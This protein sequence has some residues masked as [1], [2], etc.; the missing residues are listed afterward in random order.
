M[1][2][3][4]KTIKVKTGNCEHLKMMKLG[5]YPQHCYQIDYKNSYIHFLWLRRQTKPIKSKVKKC[6]KKIVKKNRSIAQNWL[7]FHKNSTHTH[8]RYAKRKTI[9]N[10][11]PVVNV[12]WKMRDDWKLERMRCD[13]PL[14]YYVVVRWC[15]LWG[16]CVKDVEW[17]LYSE[18][19]S[20]IVKGDPFIVKLITIFY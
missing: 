6:L 12:Q 17:K 5:K 13:I 18:N 10:A 11:H 16:S 20:P 19:K 14:I 8:T 9:W 3:L 2:N 7:K 1:K 15:W 4:V